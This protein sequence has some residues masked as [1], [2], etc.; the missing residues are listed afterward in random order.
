MPKRETLDA[1]RLRMNCPLHETELNLLHHGV[2]DADA[3]HLVALIEEGCVRKLLVAKN[4][5]SDETALAIA[6]C[7]K[8]NSTL[9]CLGL[10]S[11]N[12][13]DTGALALAEAVAS[14]ETLTSL[15]LFGN[16]I[17]VAAE[18]ALVAAN[19]SR[20]QPMCGLTGLVL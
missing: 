19:E 9:T 20:A 11:N 15:Y 2:T 5:L 16:D 12:I 13:T 6:A 14:N 7:L 17:S 18:D 4:E 1:F 3:H 8:Q 10:A